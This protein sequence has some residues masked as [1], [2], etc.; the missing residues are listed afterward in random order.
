MFGKFGG[1]VIIALSGA[2]IAGLILRPTPD[3]PPSMSLGVPDTAAS[4]AK[5]LEPTVDNQDKKPAVIEPVT[6]S[7]DATEEK[8]ESTD[9]KS[10]K[11]EVEKVTE[12]TAEKA[13]AEAEK[14]TTMA[15]DKAKAA[16]EEVKTEA[17]E[18]IDKTKEA[19]QKSE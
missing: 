19:V 15:T 14:M 3:L 13:K 5:A 8:A 2:I 6:D 17:A 10:V 11:A 7:V 9:D 4:P 1:I 18:V 16:A 12:M